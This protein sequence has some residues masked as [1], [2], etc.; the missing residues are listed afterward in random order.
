MVFKLFLYTEFI[1]SESFLVLTVALFI[2]FHVVLVFSHDK[3]D[4]FLKYEL[5]Y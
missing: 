4:C 2:K 5:L 3:S 1:G